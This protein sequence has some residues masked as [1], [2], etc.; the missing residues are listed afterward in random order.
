LLLGALAVSATAAAQT[1]AP[2]R[3][4]VDE[5][6][7]LALEGNRTLRAA[8]LEAKRA[9]E[10][11]QALLARRF[12]VLDTKGLVGSS[13]A[14]F[15]LTFPAGS[16]G[17]FPS[18]GPIPF[19][20]TD[21]TSPARPM[22]ALFVTATQPLTQLRRI[23]LGAKALGAARGVA[24]EQVRR[25][26]LDVVTSVRKAC[27]G[28]LAAQAARGAIDEALTLL[29][30]L[31]RV[32]GEYA[33]RE[34]VLPADRLAVEARLAQTELQR[35][36]V[37][38]S[39]A[40]LSEQLNVLLG[41]DVSTP[42]EIVPAPP[43]SGEP[44]LAS[45]QVR[46]AAGR[47]EVREADLR[48]AQAGF[49]VRLKQEAFVPDVSVMASYMGLYNVDILPENTAAV[50]L[51]FSWEPFDWG[52]RKLEKQAAQHQA[53]AAAL[54]QAEARDAIRVDV[55][56]H[57]RAVEEARLGLRA[58]EAEDAVARERLRVARER[59]GEQAALLKDVLDAQVAR[60]DTAQRR[61]KAELDLWTSIAELD[62]AIGDSAP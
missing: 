26:R 55:A 29:A 59:L 18:T 23:D 51:W 46:A 5:A 33:D 3:L 49:N 15:T 10:E 52:R 12:P 28:L 43:P 32:V 1:P 27:Y 24:D 47:P 19:T 54:A 61:Q 8:D 9:G 6:V 11:Q 21:I 57:H 56:A 34:V 53:D 2:A 36:R 37:D 14:P 30:E 50:G 58:A 48:A 39:I 45:A 60:A 40:T 31:R 38:H 16:L 22:V 20:D 35:A 41:R 17:T 13:L 25:R 7:A 62:Q 44:E 42:V 4:T